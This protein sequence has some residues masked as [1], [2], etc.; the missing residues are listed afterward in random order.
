MAAWWKLRVTRV[1]VIT[2]LVATFVGIPVIFMF[3]KPSA[4]RLQTALVSVNSFLGVDENPGL[5]SYVLC[6]SI[7]ANSSS[8]YSSMSKVLQ[9]FQ[10]CS[11]LF[12]TSPGKFPARFVLVQRSRALMGCRLMRSF[13][14]K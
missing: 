6:K 8:T 2:L 14:W 7:S 3:H 1:L 4:L 9:S 10:I 12:F 11:C 13:C 5:V